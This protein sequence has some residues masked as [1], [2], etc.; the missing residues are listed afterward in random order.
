MFLGGS[1]HDRDNP[2][3]WWGVSHGQLIVFIRTLVCNQK[4]GRQRSSSSRGL[5]TSVDEMMM[6]M[7]RMMM[8]MTIFYGGPGTKCTENQI[9]NPKQQNRRDDDDDGIGEGTTTNKRREPMRMSCCWNQATGD[10]ERMDDPAND[11]T[12]EQVDNNNKNNNDEEHSREDDD[13]VDD[14]DTNC[15]WTRAATDGSNDRWKQPT[16]S[17]AKRGRSD[18]TA[19]EQSRR[20]DDDDVDDGEEDDTVCDWYTRQK[21]QPSHTKSMPLQLP[22]QDDTRSLAND[23]VVEGNRRN[24]PGWNQRRTDL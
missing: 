3:M 4:D 17:T 14:G 19:I 6:M 8:I 16:E 9:S 7:M 11:S 18:D 13:D 23:T 10:G 12:M 24:Q 21:N 1:Y 15:N 5:R 22:T 2:H 20:E